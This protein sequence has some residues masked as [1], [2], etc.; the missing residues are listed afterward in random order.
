[1]GCDSVAMTRVLGRNVLMSSVRDMVNSFV[2]NYG[3]MND[4]ML[5]MWAGPLYWRQKAKPLPKTGST[6]DKKREPR[7]AK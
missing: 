4:N 1:M 5:G 6:D 7:P 2:E 3:E